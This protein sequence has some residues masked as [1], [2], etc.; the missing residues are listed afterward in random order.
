MKINIT[1]SG[2]WAHKGIYIVDVEEGIQDCEDSLA[3]ELI[4]H[5]WAELPIEKEPVKEISPKVE[6][7]R[8]GWWSVT[9]EGI[10]EISV[11]GAENAEEA[12]RMAK[13]KIE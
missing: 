6:R 5:G 9:F 8:R 4:S 2:R 12:I 13:E 10:E 11:R 1:K 3:N 7:K